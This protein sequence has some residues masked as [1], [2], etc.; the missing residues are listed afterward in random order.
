[1][2]K[3]EN[4]H[5]THSEGAH[6]D[7]LEAL[8][9]TNLSQQHGYGDDEF[10]EEARNT[11]RQLIGSDAATIYFT[12]GGTGAN[13]LSIASLLRPHEAVIAAEPGHIVGKEGGCVEAT[14]HKILVEPG[15]EGKLTPKQIQAA[16]D[17]SSLFAYQPKPKLV[18]ISNAT[19][20]GTVYIKSELQAI[21]AVCQKLNL[22]LLMD[23]ARLGAALASTK[24]DMTLQDIYQLTDVFW[25]GGTKNGALLG[26]AI[27]IKDPA[28][29]ADFPYHMKQRGRLLAK[30][31]LLGIQFSTL[32]RD[33][34]LFRLAGH[35]NEAAAEM[36]TA[37]VGM[38]Y[39]LWQATESN[40]VFVIF[41]ATLVQA[42]EE[43]FDFFVWERLNDG[44]LVVRFVTSWATE[45]SELKRLCAVVA[46]W[47][48]QR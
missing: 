24:N 6:P 17:R 32:L 10:S 8:T 14:G 31:R 15:V 46:K 27:I 43:E 37:L 13:L 9:R 44:S 23:G 3:M 33:D 42:L 2:S 4:W 18:F 19:E 36:S 7:I 21:A 5:P 34:L 16:F 22:L 47:T 12:P 41:P 38:G 45:L 28:V 11:I 39:R 40:Q 26:E 29:G 35:A 30:G 20:V 25:I 48:E 1:M